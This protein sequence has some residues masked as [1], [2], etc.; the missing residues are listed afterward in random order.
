MKSLANELTA[1]DNSEINCYNAESIELVLPTTD[2]KIAAR[3][4]IKTLDNSTKGV[5]ANSSLVFTDPTILFVRL[6]V[7]VERP[8]SNTKYF[9]LEVIPCPTALFRDHFTRPPKIWC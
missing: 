4:K 8:D 2:A 7:L 1:K 6:I 5:A 3:K 9:A